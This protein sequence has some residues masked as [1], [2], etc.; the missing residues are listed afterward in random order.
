MN[1]LRNEMIAEAKRIEPNLR[2][3]WNFKR[4]ED[5]FT[6]EPRVGKVILWFN[7]PSGTTKTVMRDLGKV[8]GHGQS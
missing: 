8:C 6:E 4:L 5:C 3:V 2:P 7:T 1:D